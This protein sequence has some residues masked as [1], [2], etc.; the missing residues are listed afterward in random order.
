M[1]EYKRYKVE[2]TIDTDHEWWGDEP[3]NWDWKN[4]ITVSDLGGIELTDVVVN[5]IVTKD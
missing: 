2:L 5:E 1:N 4:L 3:Q